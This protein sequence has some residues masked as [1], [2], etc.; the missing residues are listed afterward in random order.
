MANKALKILPETMGDLAN[1]EELYL[2][3]CKV[4]RHYFSDVKFSWMLSDPANISSS[5]L[6]SSATRIYELYPTQLEN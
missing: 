3:K 5:A 1:L 2:D 4:G 6:C